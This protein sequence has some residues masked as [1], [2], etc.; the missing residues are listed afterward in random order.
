[1]QTP[2][3]IRERRLRRSR[4]EI[5][6]LTVCEPADDGEASYVWEHMREEERGESRVDGFGERERLAAILTAERSFAVYHGEVLL[7][8]AVV[9]RLP[10]GRMF[11]SM[12][13]TTHALE[14]GHRF[15]WLRAYGPLARTL[16]ELVGDV[17]FATP[18][19]MPRALD[20]Y[21]HAGAEQTGETMTVDGREYWILKLQC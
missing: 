17:Y 2:D 9:H 6:G 16:T 19:D 4:E 14:R 21:R 13:R 5:A 18:T 3:E 1:M 7:A 20:V 12:E 10:C 8:L 15:T 11:L